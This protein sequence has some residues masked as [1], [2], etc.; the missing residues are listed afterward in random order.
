MREIIRK[1]HQEPELLKVEATIPRADN[2]NIQIWHRG[3]F[4]PAIVGEKALKLTA[5]QWLHRLGWEEL[6]GLQLSVDRQLG[7]KAVKDRL[8]GQRLDVSHLQTKPVAKNIILPPNYGW[9]DTT[10]KLN[11]DGEAIDIGWVD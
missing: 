4:R 3:M 11:E 9:Y 2:P 1:N 8:T 6:N 10:Q 7:R 5:E